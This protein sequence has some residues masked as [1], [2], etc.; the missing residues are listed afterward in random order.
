[1]KTIKKTPKQ[2]KKPNKKT[3]PKPKNPKPSLLTY[4]HRQK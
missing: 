2:S 4:Q 3:K 1:M